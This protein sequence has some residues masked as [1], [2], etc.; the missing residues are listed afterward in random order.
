MSAVGDDEAGRGLVEHARLAGIDTSQIQTLKLLP[1]NTHELFGGEPSALLSSTSSGLP[2][3]LTDTE[4][5]RE[6]D[7]DWLTIGMPA[8]D[9]ATT[10]T[11][12]ATHDTSGE[13]VVAVADVRIVTALQA[14]DMA[15]HTHSIAASQLVVIDGNF[16]PVTFASVVDRSFAA[17]VPLFFD[18]TSDVKCLLPLHTGTID[19]VCAYFYFHFSCCFKYFAWIAILTEMLTILYICLLSLS[20]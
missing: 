15:Q 16:N 8:Q 3:A 10:A 20:I 9:T 14:P 18:C 19:K 5:E 4:I 12:T 11:Y 17:N 1:R 7:A 6:T 2:D 13:L